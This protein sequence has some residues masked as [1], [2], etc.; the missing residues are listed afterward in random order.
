MPH[1]A[2]HSTARGY[3][4][5]LGAA[6]LWG[7]LGLFYTFLGE[8]FAI[9]P[10]AIAFFRAGMALLV[11]V[12]FSALFRRDWLR[13]QR[14]DLPLFLG[15]GAVGIAAF[16]LFAVYA[17]RV[18]GM[19]VA[20]VLL[21]TAPFWVTLYAW[22]FLGEGLDRFKALA[23]AG[24]V[25]GA[26]LVAQAFRPTLLRLNALGIALGLASGVCYACYSLFNKYLVRRYS[27][28]TALTFGLGFGLPLL[29]LAQSGPELWH[30]LHTPG[31]LWWLALL[32][33][34][35]TLGAG[36]LYTTALTDL[37]ASVASI[38]VAFEPVVASL[39][40]FVVLHERLSTQQLLGATIIVASIV[41]LGARDLLRRS[42]P[43]H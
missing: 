25:L 2:S 24:T 3:L 41:L 27:P 32:G 6:T 5:V 9:S 17:V 11:L 33:L 31:A 18:A 12:S 26:A 15:Q 43:P 34:V 1:P 29:G 38:I 23:L 10:P 14:R 22:L 8:R 39:L 19:S 4:L 28:W 21:Y 42:A 30:A 35:P 40:A 13:I 36:L 37:P 20:A 16:Y 7:T